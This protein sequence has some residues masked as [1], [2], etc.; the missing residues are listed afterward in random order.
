MPNELTNSLKLVAEKVAGYVGQVAELS[1]ETK[2]VEIG[3]NAVNFADA[4]PIASTIIKLD[5]DCKSVIPVRRAET[6]ALEVDSALFELHQRNVATA[7]EY[8]TRMMGALLQTFKEA[9]N[10]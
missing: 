5:G 9:V 8:R 4:L 2:Y 7:I 10:R 1:V 6:G 3:A